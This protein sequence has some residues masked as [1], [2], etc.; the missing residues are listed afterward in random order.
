M[1]STNWNAALF[2]SVTDALFTIQM[3]SSV[4][5]DG[6]V[7]TLL[8]VGGIVDGWRVL[9]VFGVGLQGSDC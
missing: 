6:D 1:K 5:D 4:E 3:D 9:E 7:A 8:I 2:R